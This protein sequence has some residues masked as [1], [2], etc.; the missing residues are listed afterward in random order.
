MAIVSCGNS[1]TC[2]TQ[3]D[4]G[5]DKGHNGTS[6]AIS[7]LHLRGQKKGPISVLGGGRQKKKP[8]FVF[9]PPVRWG[10]GGQFS[11]CPPFLSARKKRF[12]RPSSVP[13]SSVPVCAFI[14]HIRCLRPPTDF[15]VC[16]LLNPVIEML[17][18]YSTRKGVCNLG[19]TMYSYDCPLSTLFMVT[20]VSLTMMQCYS[21]LL[22]VVGE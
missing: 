11:F 20:I 19:L 14:Y 10:G 13:R 16:L 7:V 12:R 9:C 15:D 1:L 4:A 5:L 17:P 3:K 2:L 18:S 22:R 21:W 6:S 8:F